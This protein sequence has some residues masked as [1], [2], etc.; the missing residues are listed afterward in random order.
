MPLSRP[1]N[2]HLTDEE[3]ATKLQRGD[4]L[5]LTGLME[6]HKS[7]LYRT[8][9]RHVSN[10]EDA[11][12]LLQETFVRLYQKIDLYKPEHRFKPWLYQ[13]AIN[14]C[15]DHLRH[16]AL[17]RLLWLSDENLPEVSTDMPTPEQEVSS[18]RE[19]QR[20]Q[21][22]I[23]RLPIKLRTAFILFAVEG[24]SL[25]ECADILGVTPKT[26]ETR[27]YRAR[28]ILSDRLENFPEG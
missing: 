26:I 23:D 22:A 7:A 20:V 13:I 24:Q 16:R 6:R 4:R 3:L 27:V 21:Q 2:D 8:I 9:W 25:L 19:Y 12:D 15:R 28:K 1:L 11:Y 5:A 14:L 17:R 10:Q 18:K